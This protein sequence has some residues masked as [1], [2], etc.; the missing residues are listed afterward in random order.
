M[1]ITLLRII[2]TIVSFI[3]F[4]AIVVWTM[5]RKKTDRFEQAALLP[6]QDE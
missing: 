6:F 1:D 3:T 4:I 2:A 5:D